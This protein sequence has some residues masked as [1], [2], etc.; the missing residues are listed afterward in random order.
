MNGFKPESCSAI[1][2]GVLN[3]KNFLLDAV[4]FLKEIGLSGIS[5]YQIPNKLNREITNIHTEKDLEKIQKNKDYKKHLY[6]FSQIKE[7]YEHFQEFKS[8]E[9]IMGGGGSCME[10]TS[11][12]RSRYSPPMH[13][14]GLLNTSCFL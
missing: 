7:Y 5:D 4:S 10:S 14:H 2:E 8:L 12:S 13:L 11:H 9:I 1:P 3:E 6:A